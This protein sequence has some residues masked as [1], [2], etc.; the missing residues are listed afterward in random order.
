VGAGSSVP[1]SPSAQG[2]IE[3][4]GLAIVGR[5]VDVQELAQGEGM[6]RVAQPGE[7]FLLELAD[8]LV[9]QAQLGAQLPQ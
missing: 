9:R 4:Q 5:G 2:G 7:G 3:S 1:P 8:A 6:G